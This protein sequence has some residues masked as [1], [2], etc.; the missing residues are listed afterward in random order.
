MPK[1][2][3]MDK[4]VTITLARQDRKRL[5]GRQEF[6]GIKFD[7]LKKGQVHIDGKMSV[8]QA[9]KTLSGLKLSREFKIEINGEG[10]FVDS[11]FQEAKKLT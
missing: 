6:K 3:A 4:K 11:S 5:K 8:E 1:E 7:S 9:V 2:A 10:G